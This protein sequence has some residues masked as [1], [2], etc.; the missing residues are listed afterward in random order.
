MF[1][2]WVVYHDLH[3]DCRGRPTRVTVTVVGADDVPHSGVSEE[4]GTHGVPERGRPGL[5]LE[6]ES[7]LPRRRKGSRL[8]VEKRKTRSS[9]FP[10]VLRKHRD[11]RLFFLPSLLLLSPSCF[12]YLRFYPYDPTF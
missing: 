2:L 1:L 8:W 7:V 11:V 10:R 4:V 12:L 5:R 3:L 9:R 6:S